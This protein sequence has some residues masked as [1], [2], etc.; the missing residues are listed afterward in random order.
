[1]TT[2]DQAIAQ[3]MAFDMPPFPN[4]AP[5]IGAGRIV[6][7]GPKKRAWYILHEFQTAKG[8][9]VITGA[10]GYW[11][12][13]DATKIEVDWTGI[14]DDER[15]R[16]ELVQRQSEEAESKKRE[17]RAKFAANRARQQWNGAN[18][19]GGSP[20]LQRKQVQPENA[21]RFQEDGTVLVPMIRYDGS[22]RLV[23]LQKISPDGEKR[24]NKGM[25]KEG[26]ACRL[27]GTPKDGDTILLTEGL[28]TALSIRM[29]SE[30]EHAVYVT[31][32]CGNILPVG[33]ILRALFPSSPLIICADDD[34]ATAGNPGVTK[35]EHAAEQLGN[36]RVVVPK[37]KHRP[38]ETKWTD[39]NDLHCSEGIETVAGQIGKSISTPTGAASPAGRQ[40][41]RFWATVERLLEGY[42]LI[43]GTDTVWDGEHNE[44]ITVANLRLAEGLQPVNYWLAHSQR[45][46]VLRDNVLFDPSCTCDPATTINLFD[47]AEMHVPAEGT[48]ECCELIE[49]LQYLCGEH[50]KDQT[51]LT[52]WVIKWIAYPLQHVGAKMQTALVFAGPEGTG[53]NLFF[54][55]IKDMYG[56]YG[57]IITQTEL[58]SPYTAWRSRKLM[59]IANEVLTRQ[60]MRHQV[61]KLKNLVTEGELPI[62]EKYMPLRYEAN[63]MNLVFFSNELQPL[64]VAK[65][66]RRYAVIRTPGPLA[67]SR[68]V[69]IAAQAQ[70]G[71][72][73]ALHRYLLNVD[74][75]DF[76]PWSKPPMTEA[77]E[78]LIELGMSSV[79]LFFREWSQGLLP[80]PYTPALSD[81]VYQAYRRFCER[82]GERMPNKENRFWP[83]LLQL[84]EG[85][86]KMV[87]RVVDPGLTTELPRQR[88]VFII[89]KPAED[90]RPAEW[91]KQ[92]ICT[93]RDA[94]G[95]SA[96]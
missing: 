95:G 41:A 17:E 88:R 28:A 80:W 16:L 69:E 38:P 94:L 22:P 31:F 77:K 4:G 2:L 32:D 36:A 13:L 10:F 58:E 55:C 67:D 54:G 64:F 71:G 9:R 92:H 24:F 27:G 76:A 39:F 42:T 90:E 14:S 40:D 37:F 78:Q 60:E 1:M 68:Y 81:D 20:Y 6:R 11:G 96:K 5:T 86:R 52:D 44:I 63:H 49:L 61:G 56:R 74:L 26:A 35:A 83:E 47:P 85:A 45:R 7:Y 91:L 84:A 46:T 75:A 25:S 34:Y 65:G 79:E 93:F 82:A 87:L 70:A 50:D 3:M 30:R 33:R 66:D 21:L 62:D 19:L 18:R 53:K 23:G 8:A 73:D 43:R 89:G 59:I 48:G 57:G 72:V 51:P 15:R 29:A 12:R